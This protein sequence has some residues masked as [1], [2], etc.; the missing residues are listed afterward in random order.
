L[1][2]IVPTKESKEKG[3]TNDYTKRKIA[4]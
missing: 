3:N 1:M 4:G 2:L